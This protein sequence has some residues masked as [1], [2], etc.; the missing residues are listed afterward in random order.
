[1][2]KSYLEEGTKLPWEIEGG[3]EDR[4]GKGGQIRCGRRQEIIRK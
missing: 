1:M 3:R 4:K 2:L